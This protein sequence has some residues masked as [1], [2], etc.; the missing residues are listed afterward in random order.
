MAQA[1][2]TPATSTAS[3][4]SSPTAGSVYVLYWTAWPAADGDVEYHRD[5]Y[6][7]DE[8]VLAALERDH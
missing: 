1:E 4:W 7:N 5:I 3:T 2:P 6:G 8:R